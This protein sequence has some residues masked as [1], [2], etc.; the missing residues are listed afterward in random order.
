VFFEQITKNIHEILNSKFDYDYH[1]KWISYLFE[2]E[3]VLCSKCNMLH[4]KQ[5]I[6]L[7]K[8]CWSGWNCIFLK[9]VRIHV[10]ATL[11]IFCI[12]DYCSI[13]S[14]LF[15]LPFLNLIDIYFCFLPNTF[16]NIFRLWNIHLLIKIFRRQRNKF[17]R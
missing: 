17:R 14:R 12:P 4:G 13:L 16:N 11:N 1:K 10:T 5:C 15:I 3:N 2:F 9:Q 7:G 8:L 6:K